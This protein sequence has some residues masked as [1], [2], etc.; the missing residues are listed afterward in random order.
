MSVYK[1]NGWYFASISGQCACCKGR[2]EAMRLAIRLFDTNRGL[3]VAK[4]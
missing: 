4:H 3:P 2:L 1:K